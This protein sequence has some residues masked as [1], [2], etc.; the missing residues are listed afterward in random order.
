MGQPELVRDEY[1][2]AVEDADAMAVLNRRDVVILHDLTVKLAS[3]LQP[4]DGRVL[5]KV[6]YASSS[7]ALRGWCDKPLP[8]VWGGTDEN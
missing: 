1:T 6:R 2:L 8:N 7:K 4:L 3:D 5:E